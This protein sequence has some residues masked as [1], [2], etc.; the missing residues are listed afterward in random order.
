MK[1]AL[2]VFAC[3]VAA[4]A[5]VIGTAGLFAYVGSLIAVT[6]WPDARDSEFFGALAGGMM[7]A[8]GIGSTIGYLIFGRSDQPSGR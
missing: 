2:M 7:A 8:G 1:K 6:F 5:M 3:G 4:M